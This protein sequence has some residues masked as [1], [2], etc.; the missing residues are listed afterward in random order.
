MTTRTALVDSRSKSLVAAMR[1]HA[2]AIGCAYNNMENMTGITVF[3]L[4][5]IKNNTGVFMQMLDHV[6]AQFGPGHVGSVL[7]EKDVYG[8]TALHYF[9]LRGR[10]RINELHQ[11][12]LLGGS[13]NVTNNAYQTPE[14]VVFMRKLSCIEDKDDVGVNFNGITQEIQVVRRQRASRASDAK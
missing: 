14:E 5:A 12:F 7:N 4:L 8:N 2:C 10:H 9:A 11:L 6:S 13:M 3:G 1:T